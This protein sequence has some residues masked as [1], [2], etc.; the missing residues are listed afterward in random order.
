[1]KRSER[2]RLKQSELTRVTLRAR[3][4]IEAHKRSVSIGLILLAVLA[5]GGLVYWGW[6]ERV[7]ARAGGLLADALVVQ[8]ARIG[9]PAAATGA[10]GLTF[11]TERE[12]AEAA[13][14][15]FKAAADAYPSTDAGLFAR[16]Q[17][18][19]TLV[20]LGKLDDAATVYQQVIGAARD[21]VLRRSAE[22]GLAEAQ[23]RSGRFDQAIKTFTDLA[24]R[25]DD[26]LPVDGIL[27]QLGRTYLDAGRMKE[28]EQAFNRLVTE[29]P[30]S[31]FSEEAK[32]ALE[33]LKKTA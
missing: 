14:A 19:S 27:L 25:K 33:A 29:F 2:H 17:Q 31:P 23:A 26:D 21:G 24:Q 4:G 1:M 20:A 11:P 10:P 6:R 22:L 32:Q 12:R 15:R 28:A 8:T 13:V 5:V 7:E 3:E 18:A 16:Y 30:D 9:P